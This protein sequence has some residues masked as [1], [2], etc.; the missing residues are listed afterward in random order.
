MY[1]EGTG[2]RQNNILAHMWFNLAVVSYQTLDITTGHHPLF[3]PSEPRVG[4]ELRARL[5]YL[6]AEDVA[7]ERDAIAKQMTPADISEAQRL[8]REWAEQH[9]E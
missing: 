7:Q 1:A 6:I 5:S 9:G 4:D 2:V 8:A 3:N